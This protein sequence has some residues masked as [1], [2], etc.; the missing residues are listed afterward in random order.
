MS[1]APALIL[2]AGFFLVLCGVGAMVSEIIQRYRKEQR[3]NKRLYGH[4]NV[5][6]MKDWK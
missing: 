5:Y 2:L 4:G 6:S 3:R 1:W